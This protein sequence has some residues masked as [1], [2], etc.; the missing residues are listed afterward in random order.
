MAFARQVGKPVQ[1]AFDVGFAEAR[2]F[3]VARKRLA[4]GHFRRLVEH[5]AVEDVNEDIEDGAVHQSGNAVKEC[6]GPC[7][8]PAIKFEDQHHGGDGTGVEAG[9]VD[10]IVDAGRL[11]AEGI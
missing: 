7:F 1:R 11:E 5:V 10:Q 8:D 6:P 9:P 3:K 2:A 4:L